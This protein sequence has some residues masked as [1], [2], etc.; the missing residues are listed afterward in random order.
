MSRLE[1]DHARGWVVLVTTLEGR[2][3]FHYQGGDPHNDATLIA[4]RDILVRLYCDCRAQFK[5]QLRSSS[6]EQAAGHCFEALEEE[7]LV[8][9]SLGL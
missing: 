6:C 2:R 3:L 4:M 1:L 7:R 8:H 5:R 9:A